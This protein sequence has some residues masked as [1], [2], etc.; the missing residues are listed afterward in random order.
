MG[1]LKAQ[2]RELGERHPAVTR[3]S[4]RVCSLLLQEKRARGDILDDEEEE[5]ALARKPGR[6]TA[7]QPQHIEEER[8]T[9]RAALREKATREQKRKTNT[10][11][12]SGFDHIA[13]SGSEG[14]GA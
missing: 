11:D 2:T 6:P 1:H 14:E 4:P 9:R 5:A 12:Y 13:D 7:Q 3:L 8:E 10:L